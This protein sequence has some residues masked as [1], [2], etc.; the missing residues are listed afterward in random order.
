MLE[1]HVG[2]GLRNMLHVL[3]DHAQCHVAL[4][5]SAYSLYTTL[6]YTK[7]LSRLRIISTY[8]ASVRIRH[9]RSLN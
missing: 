3:F 7:S 8:G 2:L 5:A 9:R 1:E 6:V 4:C